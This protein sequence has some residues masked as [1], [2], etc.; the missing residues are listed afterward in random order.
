[1][2]LLMPSLVVWEAFVWKRGQA[3][4]GVADSNVLPVIGKN[5]S[6]DIDQYALL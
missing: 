5:F 4:T 1:M 3:K 6:R 2:T